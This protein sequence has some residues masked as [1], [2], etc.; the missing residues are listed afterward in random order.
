MFGRN[1][2]AG[3]INII[4]RQPGDDAQHTLRAEGALDRRSQNLGQLTFSGL[5]RDE[6]LKG[7]FSVA[8]ADQS[9][10]VRKQNGAM[11]TTL[12]ATPDEI[13]QLVLALSYGRNRLMPSNFVLQGTP[14][15]PRVALDPKGWAHR[16]TGPCR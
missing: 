13:T 6:M 7:S 3:A 11:R 14:N 12:L 1:A 5:L 10:D 16:E 15:F 4:T 8:Y 2:Q 9:G